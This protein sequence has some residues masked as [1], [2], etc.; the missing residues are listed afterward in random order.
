VG[1]EAQGG[2]WGVGGD[3][4]VWRFVCL[5]GLLVGW[6]LVGVVKFLV[7]GGGVLWLGG[8]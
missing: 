2:V 4:G 1:R 8:E 6:W 7:W 3:E 5:G